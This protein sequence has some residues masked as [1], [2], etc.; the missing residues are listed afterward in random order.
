MLLAIFTL[1]MVL[2][3]SSSY[4]DPTSPNCSVK[5]INN[6]LVIR[7]NADN[8]ELIVVGH[9]HRDYETLDTFSKRIRSAAQQRGNHAAL[10]RAL[11]SI[12]RWN[13]NDARRYF[14]STSGPV[15]NQISELVRNRNVDFIG[16]ESP[17]VTASERI[18]NIREA[19]NLY[20]ELAGEAYGIDYLR[21]N[22]RADLAGMFGAD[23]YHATV[24]RNVPTT[25]GVDSSLLEQNYGDSFQDLANAVNTLDDGKNES[26]KLELTYIIEKLASGSYDSAEILSKA[27]RSLTPSLITQVEKALDARQRAGD[28]YKRRDLQMLRSM[29]ARTNR[30]GLLVVGSSHLNSL[31]NQYTTYCQSPRVRGKM[32]TL[33]V[34]TNSTAQ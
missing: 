17:Y 7:D 18:E 15:L 27:K 28:A 23:W 2:M 1:N 19:S 16:I 29:K 33:S 26:N 30:V 11:A 20:T 5:S 34:P 12:K 8:S 4:G 6:T 3:I 14:Q 13:N 22:L 31:R 9:D 10:R 25:Q 32:E 21:D 24:P